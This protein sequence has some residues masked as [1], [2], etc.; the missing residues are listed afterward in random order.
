MRRS[1]DVSR[2][3]LRT[4]D[5][6]VE[7]FGLEPEDWTLLMG[8]GAVAFLIN[9][10]VAIGLIVGGF[11]ILRALKRGKPPGY[12]FYLA[13]KSGLTK[14]LPMRFRPPGL[15]T[16]GWWFQRPFSIKY[17]AYLHEPKSLDFWATDMQ[18][19]ETPS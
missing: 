7:I 4:L 2:P 18:I 19:T 17:S 12:I 8:V 10:I 9:G 15:V 11:L 14:L 3:C 13:Y 1:V 16:R 5:E 6:A